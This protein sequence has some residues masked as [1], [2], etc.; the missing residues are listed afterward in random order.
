MLRS[1]H[2]LIRSALLRGAALALCFAPPAF[3]EIVGIQ[4]ISSSRAVVGTPTSVSIEWRVQTSTTVADRS[5][6]IIS[7]EA[8]VTLEGSVTDI[9][10]VRV[11]QPLKRLLAPATSAAATTAIFRETLTIPPEITDAAL[12]V[13]LRIVV[14]R[15][16]RDQETLVPVIGAAN[17]AIGGGN[18]AQLN[19]SRIEL[20]FPD[21]TADKIMASGTRSHVMATIHYSGTGRFQAVWEIAEPSSTGGVPMFRL[22]STVYRNLVSGSRT[23]TLRSPEL[24]SRTQGT[25]LLRLRV[26]APD[27]NAM[28]QIRYAVSRTLQAPPEVVQLVAY[29]PA[30]GAVYASDTRFRWSPTEHAAVYQIEFFT[31]D[32][33]SIADSLPE[34]D[35]DQNND[36]HASAASDLPDPTAGIMITAISTQASLSQLTLS[37]L[38]PGRTY[39]WRV[40]AYDDQG[41]MVGTSALRSIRLPK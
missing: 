30:P 12:A 29:A 35:G 6:A 5:I 21:N 2:S 38:A 15:E 32:A 19:V 40:T 13:G 28:T 27:T 4:G 25:Y 17:I 3:A 22:L 33:T 10:R 34:L 1:Y 39:D 11:P 8:F 24:P 26:V 23:L 36:R 9:S 14:V 41:R 37:Q 18:T 20:R 7:S 31:R 16:F